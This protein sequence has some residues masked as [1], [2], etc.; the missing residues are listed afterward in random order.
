M[1]KRSSQAGEINVLL[2]PLILLT[3]FLVAAAAFGYWAYTERQ[4]YK[5][6]SDQKAAVAAT[7]A[8]REEG[9]AKDKAFIEA[10]KQPLTAFDGPSAFGSI[11]VD[12]P[13]TWS[14]YINSTTTSNQPLDAY[15]NPRI[16]PSV[17]DQTSVFALRVQ[18]VQQSYSK[19]VASFD[20]AV[21]KGT[22]TITPYT[23]PKV[24][25]VVGVRAD[26]LVR[27]GKKTTG[28]IVIMP[29]RD[30][31]IQIWTENAQAMNDFNTIILPNVTFSP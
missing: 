26:G 12:Y 27:P 18:V 4:D 22:V 24:P 31:S 14:V 2:V 25:D 23:L 1:N 16:V 20:A 7:E 17:Q 15:F 9:I 30:K 13:K 21:K 3:L 28:S 11:H 29:L 6:N 19:L 8:R 10:E 5:N